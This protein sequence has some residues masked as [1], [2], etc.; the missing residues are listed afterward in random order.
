MYWLFQD[1]ELQ[2]LRNIGAKWQLEV[3]VP[4]AFWASALVYAQAV[5]FHA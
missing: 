3:V 5:V 1:E 2:G 4:D